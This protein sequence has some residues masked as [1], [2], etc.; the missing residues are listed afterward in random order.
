ME[1]EQ[2]VR[3]YLEETNASC[4]IE[5]G[6]R[7]SVSF[8]SGI[9]PLLLWLEEDAAC[10]RGA[11]AADKIVGRA[12][13]LLLAYGGAAYVYG[14]VMSEGARQVLTD[15]HIRFDSGRIVE[16]IRNR[17]GTGICPMEQRVLGIDEPQKAYETLRT[18][19]QP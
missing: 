5:K 17:Q 3:R 14:A 2:A 15:H 4:V 16:S 12:A 13:A 9:R 10:L 8:D 6:G 18:A 1:A 11:V 19:L 7:R